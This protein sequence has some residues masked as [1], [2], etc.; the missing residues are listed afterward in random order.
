MRKSAIAVA[1]ALAAGSLVL[2]GC[3]S[4]SE[5]APAPT[6]ASPTQSETAQPPI[7]G[8][9]AT[10]A[11]VEINPTA[12]QTAPI[13]MVPNQRAVFVGLKDGQAYKV[14]SQ[15]STIVEGVNGAAGERPGIIALKPGTSVVQLELDGAMVYN[16]I[17]VEVAP[18]GTA[19][20]S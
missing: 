5:P 14:V 10:W 11:P 20:A 4:S 8:D 1:A 16:A 19:P 3:S 2:V 7:G 13:V 18:E 9:P 15:D 12:E 6:S 17:T